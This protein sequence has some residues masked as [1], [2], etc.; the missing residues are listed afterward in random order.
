MGNEAQKQTQWEPVRN[1]IE[2]Q[3]STKHKDNNKKSWTWTLLEMMW[4]TRK[5]MD[6]DITGA[7]VVKNNKEKLS[8]GETKFTIDGACNKKRDAN[9]ETGLDQ[10][11]TDFD[12]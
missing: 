1:G 11:M 5:L 6:L 10:L 7:D 8:M 9:T 2:V 4:S 12:P 3:H